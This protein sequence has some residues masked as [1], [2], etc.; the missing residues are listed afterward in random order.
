MSKIEIKTLRHVDAKGARFEDVPRG[1]P[2]AFKKA[3]YLKSAVDYI[4][5]GKRYNA[6][7]LN[8]GHLAWFEGHQQVKVPSSAA[9]L[10]LK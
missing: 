6:V 9:T 3:A 1:T 7:L 10:V 8:K 4:I 2:F 5:D